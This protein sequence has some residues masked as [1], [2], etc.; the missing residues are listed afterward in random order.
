MQKKLKDLETAHSNDAWVVEK[1]NM[2]RN[3]DEYMKEIKK[4]NKQCS[5]Y[6][7]QI[8]KMKKDVRAKKIIYLS[9]KLF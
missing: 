5:Q 2:K 1:E 6:V 7:E 3:L 8:E 9:Q 4:L